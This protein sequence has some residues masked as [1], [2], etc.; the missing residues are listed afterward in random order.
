MIKFI[1]LMSSVVCVVCSI[2]SAS[3]ADVSHHVSVTGRLLSF[4]STYYPNSLIFTMDRDVGQCRSG[5]FLE[6]KGSGATDE[7]R[8]SNMEG[9]LS[10]L[11]LALAGGLNGIKVYV[12]D[13]VSRGKTTAPCQIEFLGVRR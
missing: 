5:E 2:F 6:Y 8:H 10:T 3:S 9:A 12:T 13:D 4:E 7:E 1:R 11:T